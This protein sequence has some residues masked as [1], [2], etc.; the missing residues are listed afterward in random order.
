MYVP[1]ATAEEYAQLFPEDPAI[2]GE[3]LRTASRHI[4]TLTFNRIVA[5]GFENLTEFQQGIIKEAVCRQAR[6]ETENE[7]LIGSVLSGYSI[8]GVSMQFG[9]NWNVVTEGGVAMKR[10]VYSLLEQSGLSCRLAGSV[11]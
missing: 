4:D 5:S 3:A 10:D 7:D 11:R 8:N 1:Y 9:Q 2:S 6:F